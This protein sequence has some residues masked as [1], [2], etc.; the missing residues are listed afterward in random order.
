MSVYNF[1][2]LALQFKFQ[3]TLKTDTGNTVGF[4]LTPNSPVYKSISIFTDLTKE[5]NIALVPLFLSGIDDK[6][7]LMQSDGIHPTADAQAIMLEN[8]WPTLEGLLR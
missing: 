5:N 2:F 3:V 6:A 1:T 7:A 4:I 8:V